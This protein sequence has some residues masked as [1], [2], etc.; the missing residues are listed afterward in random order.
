[1][2]ILKLKT[3][4]FKLVNIFKTTLSYDYQRNRF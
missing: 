3:Q 1:M 2:Q 4:R